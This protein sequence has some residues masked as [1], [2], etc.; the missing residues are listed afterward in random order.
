MLVLEDAGGEPLQ[1]LLLD[2]PMKVGR[3][4]RQAIGIAMALGEFHKRG[5][6]HKDVKPVKIL[7]N[8][9]T[10][11]ARLTGSAL[12]LASPASHRR[13]SLP[14]IAGCLA[15]GLCERTVSGCYAA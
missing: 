3:F 8:G 9:V 7:V 11:D 10:G 14:R 6:V 1:R 4:L 5:L 12:H 2:P 13:A 15:G